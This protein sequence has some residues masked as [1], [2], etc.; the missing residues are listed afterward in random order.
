MK[1]RN[2]KSGSGYVL[3]GA[4]RELIGYDGHEAILSGPRDT[5]KT[6]AGCVKG[7]LWNMAMPGSQGAIFRKANVTLAGT[8]LQTWTRVIAPQLAS[9]EVRVYGGERPERYIYQNGSV[10][11]CGGMDN[12]SKAL[13]SERD[14]IFTC[15][16]E[17]F[18]EGEWETLAGSCSG[19]GAVCHKPQI[20]GDCNPAGSKHWIR[21]RA[22]RG[23][24]KLLAAVHKDNPTLYD[25]AGNLTPDGE[26]RLAVLQAYTGVRRKR[27]FSGLWVTAEGAVYENFDPAVHVVYRPATQFKRFLLTLD[28]GFTNPWALLVVGVDGDGRWHVLRE[29]YKTN[30]L[31]LY[32]T[33]T[34]KLL[35]L[36][37]AGELPTDLKNVWEGTGGGG[38]EGATGDRCE[39]CCVDEARPDVVADLNDAGVYARGG[40]GRVEAG[41]YKIMDRLAV[42]GDGKPRLTVDP[43][44]VETINEFESY[45]WKEGKSKEVPVDK[46]NHALDALRYLQEVEGE[47]TGAFSGAHVA[48]AR[49]GRAVGVNLL[50]FGEQ[51]GMLDGGPARLGPEDM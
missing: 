48:G 35:S 49:T 43:R 19:R 5:G 11:W 33:R 18:T 3:R 47:P 9:G 40:K 34:A 51:S 44:C 42:A 16:T 12:P 41:I 37:W 25:A 31:P 4:N 8:V 50:D 36:N 17:E 45:V 2:V 46:D 29:F 22:K 15:Q 21:E 38:H 30:V 6:V 26:R 27:L 13:S 10:V 39:M 1:L 7:H 20:F 28:V 32:V 23:Q 14:W 24:L